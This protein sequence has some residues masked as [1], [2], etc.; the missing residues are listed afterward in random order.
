MLTT[1]KVL[2][3]SSS[4]PSGISLHLKLFERLNNLE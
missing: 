1:G 2:V 4:T 3:H